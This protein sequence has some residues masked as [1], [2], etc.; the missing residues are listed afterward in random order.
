YTLDEIRN[1]ITRTTPS[2]YEPALDYVVTK[3]PR[4]AFEKF[5]G[6]AD[7]LTTA[8]KSVGEVMGIGR[9]SKESLMK[10]ISSLE[11]RED[12]LPEIVF[13]ENL[14]AHPNSLRLY[15]IVQAYREGKTIEY[16]QSLTQITPWFLEQINQIVD[17][18]DEIRQAP[19][20]THEFL[21]QTKR[22]GFS[23]AQ[24]ARL[25]A[26]KAKE[27]RE[28]RWKMN[29]HPGYS[30]VDTCAGEFASQTPYYYSSYWADP[31]PARARDENKV[32]IL[33]S[34]PNRIGQGI[35]FDYSCVRG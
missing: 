11:N 27:I 2:C 12:G 9:T 13:D 33:G 14:L 29:L 21:L 16:V 7:S 31:A 18:E 34:G 24:I 3:I 32:V 28:L 30:Q 35:E 26:V 15:Q 5:P 22:M 23:D 6:T 25:R 1:D 10:A 19:Q 8:M 17:F 20:L 4:F